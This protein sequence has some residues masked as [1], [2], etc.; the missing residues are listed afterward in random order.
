V[1]MKIL[2]PWHSGALLILVPVVENGTGANLNVL[3]PWCKLSFGA[4]ERNSTSL[5][6]M[7]MELQVG[8]WN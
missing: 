1:P 8:V 5:V 6:A 7:W 3:A 4:N 2:A